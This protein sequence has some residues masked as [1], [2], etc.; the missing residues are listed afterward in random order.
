MFVS[1]FA[2]EYSVVPHCIR[3]LLEHLLFDSELFRVPLLTFKFSHYQTPIQFLF[4][5]LLLDTFSRKFVVHPKLL[6]TLFSF[7]ALFRSSTVKW[8]FRRWHAAF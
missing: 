8:P 3:T 5:Q 6:R 1:F 4:V 2:I 7:P